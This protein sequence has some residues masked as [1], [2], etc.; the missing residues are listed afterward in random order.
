MHLSCMKIVR[1]T[2]FYKPN[3]YGIS[4]HTKEGST[5]DFQISLHFEVLQEGGGVPAASK[6]T[7][8]KFQ[9]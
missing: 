9:W 8:P 5:E 3:M 2:N 4:F 6:L 7:T 1:R